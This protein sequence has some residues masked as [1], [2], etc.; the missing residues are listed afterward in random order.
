MAQ[1]KELTPEE[2]A[3]ADERYRFNLAIDYQL[4]SIDLKK[5]RAVTDWI[6][7]GD[8]AKLEAL[9]QHAAVLRSQRR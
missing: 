5:I 7:T 9:E 6:L 2:Q 4:Q 8:K 1:D 3:A